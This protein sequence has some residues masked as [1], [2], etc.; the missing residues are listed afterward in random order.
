MFSPVVAVSHANRDHQRLFDEAN[1]Q[2]YDSV[3]W[4]LDISKAEAE[5]MDIRSVPARLIRR[6]PETQVVITRAAAASGEWRKLDL[7]R[8][9]WSVAIQGFLNDGNAD[10]VLVAPKRSDRFRDLLNGLRM[11][12]QVGVAE[13][14]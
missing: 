1:K 3:D 7:S 11:L 9:Y 6:D 13:P 12:R 14:D 2:F 4:A 5:E 8:T 10:L